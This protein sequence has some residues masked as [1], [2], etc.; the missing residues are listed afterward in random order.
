MTETSP[1]HSCRHGR[2]RTGVAAQAGGAG[3]LQA[4]DARGATAL[5]VGARH[6]P[7]IEAFELLLQRSVE[8]GGDGEPNGCLNDAPC[9]QCTRHGASIRQ[10]FGAGKDV[11]LRP[12]GLGMLP[13]HHAAAANPAAAVCELLLSE[14]AEAQLSA[15][16]CWG[17]TPVH[18]AACANASAAV[19]DVLLQRVWVRQ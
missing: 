19:L 10:F 7:S 16:D 8:H 17:R 14:E 2:E 18:W 15:R 6:S 1:W 13:L 3:Q 12:D 4:Q 9:S 11:R 5:H